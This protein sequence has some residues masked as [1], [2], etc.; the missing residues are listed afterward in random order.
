MTAVRLL[1][2]FL[3]ASAALAT[4]GGVRR[5]VA[6]GAAHRSLRRLALVGRF[7][8]GRRLA[9]AL[10]RAGLAVPADAFVGMVAVG[11]TAVGL[12]AL[13]L[14]RSQVVGVAAAAGGIGA[15]WGFVSSADRRYLAR[16]SSQLP[17]VAQQLGSA[18]GAGLSLRQAIGRTARDAPEPAASELGRLAR[19]LDLGARIDVALEETA[20]RLPDPGLRIMVVAI[21]VQRVVGGNLA[22]ALTDLSARLEE[23]SA[24][25]REARSATAQA[26]MSAWLVGGLPLAGGVLV[27]V[28]APGTVGRTLGQGFGLIVVAVASLLQGIAVVLIR[29]V[30]NRNGVLT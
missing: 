9:A 11:S 7:A 19:D 3:A 25:E 22:Q 2:A 6:D 20:A 21:L 1:P 27:E 18:I 4:V 26:K 12:V 16:F 17:V 15:A 24:L 28:V 13:A 5:L 29:R 8:A 14:T 10:E 30:I 23:R